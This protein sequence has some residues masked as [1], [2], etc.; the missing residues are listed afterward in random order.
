M[1]IR[2]K[3]NSMR[4]RLT[5]SEVQTFCETGFFKE[6]TDFGTRTFTYAIATGEGEELLQATFE[7]AT[8][9]LFLNE[10]ERLGWAD[11]AQVGFRHTMPLGDGRE[12]TLL[13]EKDFVC[14]DESVEDQTDNYPN[15]RA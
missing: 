9:T 1:K 14:M 6:T 8:I 3:G 4:Y 7:D 12:L 11:S 5:K 2:I 15:P 10:K 13:L